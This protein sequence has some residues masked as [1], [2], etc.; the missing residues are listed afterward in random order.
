MRVCPS[1]IAFL[2]VAIDFAALA[3]SQTVPALDPQLPYQAMRSNPVTYTVDFSVVVTPPYQC[4]KLKVWLPVPTSD[5]GQDISDSVLTSFPKSIEPQLAN[6]P[7]FGNRF[8]YFEF[9]SPQG[10][11][12]ITHRFK[13]TVWQLDWNLDQ[14]QLTHVQEWPT[15]FEAYRR[16]ESQAVVVD[17]RFFTLLD[18]IVPNRATPASDFRSA[19]QWV[20]KTFEYDHHDASLSASSVHGL[21]KRR[22]HCS[23][24]HGFCASIGRALGVPT[25]V[26]YGINTFP[27][28]S[29]SHCKLEAYLPPFGW[30]SFDVSETQKLMHAIQRSETLGDTDKA[31]LIR[32]A[33]SRLERG[34]RDN[35]WF[36]QTRGTDYELAPK[37]M[38]RVAVV[39]TA[40]IEADDMI[41]PEPDPADKTQVRHAW[42]TAHRFEADR[43]VPYPFT[44]WTTL[45]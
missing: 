8:A 25:R 22:G 40:Y 37:A 16:G 6:E 11:Q 9:D 18:E 31:E 14:A 2:V 4:K 32:R 45:P 1:L 41:Y 19:M 39:R 21:T 10:A 28:N 20:Q 43:E 12:I 15:S 24:Y 42:M 5:I 35:T 44:D 30:V 34:F 29:P 23:D 17:E 7:V 26:T 3:H 33:Q 36:L 27:K 13:A 38:K